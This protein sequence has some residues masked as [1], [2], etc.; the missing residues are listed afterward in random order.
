MSC[1]H[2]KQYIL[3]LNEN[4]ACAF[5][6]RW[7]EWVTFQGQLKRLCKQKLIETVYFSIFRSGFR[8]IL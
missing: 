2:I 7:N 8:K 3:G 5:H 4:S 6:I 1:I